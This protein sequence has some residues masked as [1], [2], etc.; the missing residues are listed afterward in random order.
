[1]G[2]SRSFF[3]QMATSG[4]TSSS[5][6]RGS[7]SRRTSSGST[8]SK[9][10]A[11]GSASRRP[12]RPSPPAGGRTAL[13]SLVPSGRTRLGGAASFASTSSSTMARMTECLN[14]AH[15]LRPHKPTGG[16]P[17]PAARSTPASSP[18]VPAFRSLT[19]TDLELQEPRPTTAGMVS[20]CTAT[21]ETKQAAKARPRSALPSPAGRLKGS[22]TPSPIG[23]FPPR[24]T[25]GGSHNYY[26]DNHQADD[27]HLSCEFSSCE[28]DCETAQ[29]VV[30]TMLASSASEPVLPNQRSG[31]PAIK[32]ALPHEVAGQ[33]PASHRSALPNALFRATLPVY[34]PNLQRP[35]S[36]PPPGGWPVA[37]SHAKRKMI[38]RH[39]PRPSSSDCY[40]EMTASNRRPLLLDLT[41]KLIPVEGEQGD[42]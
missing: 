11:S 31:S 1:M 33:H 2:E 15:A 30:S 13:D 37:K 19:T 24:T 42:A 18:Y 39:R 32:L 5:A 3:D 12:T 25:T 40:A 27:I 8:Y 7:N 21:A 6:S 28:S 14:R 17:G 20:T 10:L 29:N 38:K 4:A 36:A 23:D 35:R 16:A 41:W 22:R 26:H 34:N 9:S